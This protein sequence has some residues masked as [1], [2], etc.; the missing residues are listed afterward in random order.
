MES[1]SLQAALALLAAS[2]IVMFSFGCEDKH[3]PQTQTKTTEET[4]VNVQTHLLKA[5]AF[6]LDLVIAKLKEGKL[7]DAKELEKFINTEPGVNNV[8]IDKDG[9]L[10]ELTVKEEQKDG[11]MIMAVIAHPKKENETVVAEIGFQKN[12]KTEEVT[13]TGA[14]PEYVQGHQNHY[15]N[16][17]LTGSVIG[18][19]MF[20]Q[21]MFSPRP[22]YYHPYSYG[23]YYSSPRPVMSQQ[24]VTQTRTNYRKTNNVGPV[25]KAQKPASYKPQTK[26]AQKSASGF[27]A[28][29]D[30]QKAQRAKQ[31]KAIAARKQQAKT[32]KNRGTT[33][34]PKAGGFKS[35]PSRGGGFKSSP[36]RSYGGGSRRSNAD[37]K[38]NIDYLTPNEVREYA[39][40]CYDLRLT[41]WNYNDIQAND[42]RI[43]LGIITQDV[44]PGV[45]VT[46]DLDS[47]DLYGYTS[48]AIAAIQHQQQELEALRREVKLVRQEC[49]D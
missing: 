14:Y 31:Q 9:E 49:A 8:D 36:S 24:Q 2:L 17:T 20:Y 29:Q 15:Y 42:D 18:D 21:W 11:K 34:K 7:Q 47:V 38:H 40:R 46:S 6:G 27:K 41:T 26:S 45:A 33:S 48:L 19:M 16:H 4:L 39:E 28:K 1:K 32:I 5:D 37:Y 35:K 10:D 43:H 3:Q 13:I 22:M 25:A 23:M 12:T 30:A 44:G